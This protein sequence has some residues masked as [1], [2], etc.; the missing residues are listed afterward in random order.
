VIRAPEPGNA[1]RPKGSFR[2]ARPDYHL[3]SIFLIAP[4]DA[5][6]RKIPTEKKEV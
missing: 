4:S 2:R 1:R 5:V 6:S 3:S